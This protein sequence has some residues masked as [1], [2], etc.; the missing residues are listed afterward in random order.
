MRRWVCTVFAV[1]VVGS[2]IG[3]TQASARPASPSPVAPVQASFGTVAINGGFYGWANALSVGQRYV[4]SVPVRALLAIAQKCRN[5]TFFGFVSLRRGGG[6]AGSFPASLEGCLPVTGG[7]PGAAGCL[8]ALRAT[9]S[10]WVLIAATTDIACR[11]LSTQVPG[12][13]F[14]R[15]V[16]AFNGVPVGNVMQ[17][18]CQ[19]LTTQR[20]LWD[21]VV[22]PSSQRPPLSRAGVFIPHSYTVSNFQRSRF[23]PAC[24]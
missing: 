21:F 5:V 14:V 9:T 22:P 23:V 17:V 18:A 10:A 6:V 2:L 3:A 1:A 13:S 8:Q 12:G 19:E 15:V 20:V 4:P 11:D 16:R 24:S 7:G